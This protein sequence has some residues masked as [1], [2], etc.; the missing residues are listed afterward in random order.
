MLQ[1]SP[2]I[3]STRTGN[4]SLFLDSTVTRDDS[5]YSGVRAGVV[6]YNEDDD[7]QV[8]YLEFGM[9]SDHLVDPLLNTFG[10]VPPRTLN[11]NMPSDYDA[12]VVVPRDEHVT[13]T[14]IAD[15]DEVTEAVA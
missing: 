13:V 15:S 5:R 11:A 8:S 6:T 12:N 7:Y 9:R 10:H 3:L 2:G 4:V 1:A 14:T